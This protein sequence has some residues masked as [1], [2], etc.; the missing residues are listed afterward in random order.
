MSIDWQPL[1]EI[2]NSHQSFLLT[3]HCRADC[4]ALGSELALA[5]VLRSLGKQAT[6]VNGDCA[7]TTHVPLTP[8]KPKSLRRTARVEAT[9]SK[10]GAST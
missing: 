10:Q 9:T 6:I 7:C 8:E 5:V 2:I 1:V 3:S 4:D